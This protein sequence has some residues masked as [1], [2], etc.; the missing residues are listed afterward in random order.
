MAH[1][2]L[3]HAA[4]MRG[5]EVKRGLGRTLGQ[6]GQIVRRTERE[7]DLLGGDLMIDAGFDLVAA[8]NILTRL[9]SDLGI[10]LFASHEPAGKRIATL[11]ALAAARR[12]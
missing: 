6:S 3:G 5:G 9:G 12:P 10:A 7:A 2:I 11:R 1:N 8:T 4:I